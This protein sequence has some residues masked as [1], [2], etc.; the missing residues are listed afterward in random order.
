MTTLLIIDTMLLCMLIGL[1]TAC[2]TAFKRATIRMENEMVSIAM[3]ISKLAEDKADALEAK[4]KDAEQ[5]A[6]MESGIS[7][8]LSY[9]YAQMNKRRGEE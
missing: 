5:Q 4:A 9:G 2:A 6:D 3:N 1:C 7:A 8:I